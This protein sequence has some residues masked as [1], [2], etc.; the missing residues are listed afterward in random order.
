MSLVYRDRFAVLD[1]MCYE[2]SPYGECY[3][4]P[5]IIF[6]AL[7]PRDA[8]TATNFPDDTHGPCLSRGVVFVDEKGGWKFYRGLRLSRPCRANY[9]TLYVQ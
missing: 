2:T 4:R 8:R 5:A 9:E 7:F 6:L 1:R 3:T